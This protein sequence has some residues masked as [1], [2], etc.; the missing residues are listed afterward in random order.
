MRLQDIMNTD[1]EVIS[2]DEP[3]E[4]AQYRMQLKQIHHLVVVGKEENVVGIISDTDFK[5]LPK[6]R[7]IRERSRVSDMMTRDIVTAKPATTIKNAANLLR[8]H[9][10]G[11]LPVMED[12]HLVGIITI[13][14]LLEIIGRG[15]EQFAVHPKH[16]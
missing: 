14:D 2:E 8:G 13:S 3:A 11:C 9:T 12:H 4:N 10:I 1:V 5:A 15:V 6:K 16:K 7:S